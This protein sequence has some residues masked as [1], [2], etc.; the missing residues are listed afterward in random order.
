MKPILITADP[1]QFNKEQKK[2]L[3][4]FA[5]SLMDGEVDVGNRIDL[6]G[7][8]TVREHMLSLLEEEGWFY[9]NRRVLYSNE[10]LTIASGSVS[11]HTDSGLGVSAVM[12]LLL[13]GGSGSRYWDRLDA[14]IGE[15]SLATAHGYVSGS[16]GD[17][18]V[19]NAD[20]W[21]AWICNHCCVMYTMTVKK[22]RGFRPAVSD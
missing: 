18:I 21:H 1:I 15:F 12:P 6:P 16:L 3:K 2:V 11:P 20:V 10:D 22:K 5:G 8:Q 14:P 19:F 17:I 4:G 13:N 9:S 7:Y